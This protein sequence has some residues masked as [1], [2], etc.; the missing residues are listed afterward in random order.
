M[1]VT[2]LF[3]MN[4]K[5][6]IKEEIN[7]FDWVNDVPEFYGRII[8]TNESSLSK[9][10]IMTLLHNQGY[11]WRNAGPIISSYNVVLNPYRYILVGP[12]YLTDYKID[13]KY[14]HI[15]HDNSLHYSINGVSAKDL[16]ITL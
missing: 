11:S 1:D 4:I 13:I 6:I 5:E 10:E 3:Y 2:Y 9:K 8:D 16:I 15:L 7:D 14:G 12:M